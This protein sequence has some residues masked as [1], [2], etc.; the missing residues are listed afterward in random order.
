MQLEEETLNRRMADSHSHGEGGGGGGNP[1]PRA[2]AKPGTPKGEAA[3]SGAAQVAAVGADAAR[4]IKSLSSPR[5]EEATKGAP[6][7]AKEFKPGAE[8]AGASAQE[9]TR[10]PPPALPPTGASPH[11]GRWKWEPYSTPANAGAAAGD[12]ER[13]GGEVKDGEGG[14]LLGFFTGRR[15]ESAPSE[16]HR[17]GA[18]AQSARSSRGLGMPC[19]TLREDSRGNVSLF[20]MEPG[21]ALQR[22]GTVRSGDI[23]VEIDGR[24]A[25][26]CTERQ[27]RAMLVADKGTVCTISWISPDKVSLHARAEM[28]RCL[29]HTLDQCCCMVLARPSSLLSRCALPFVCSFVA[30]GTWGA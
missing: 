28:Q 8:G 3:V 1:S 4:W 6:G 16:A 13:G 10:P 22:L 26:G 21:G 27:V 23:I 11:G 29:G 9:G 17:P 2:D 24:S 18:E 15:G 14:G 30:Y 12:I 20:G 25:L 19:I 7:G 5:A